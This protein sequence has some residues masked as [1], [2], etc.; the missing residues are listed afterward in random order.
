MSKSLFSPDFTHQNVLLLQGPVGPFFRRLSKDLMALGNRVFKINFNAGDALFYPSHAIHFKGENRDLLA[1]L[2]QFI[3]ANGIHC[4]AL[5]GDCRP[6]H[7]GVVDLAK[8]LGLTVYVF[9]EG[10]LRPDH[11]TIEQFGVNG[12]SSIPKN[13]D[14]YHDYAFESKKLSR[15]RVGS[16][17]WYAAAWAMLYYFAA[18]LGHLLFPKY[19]HHRPLRITEALY[20]LRGAWRKQMFKIRERGIEQR[21][22]HELSKQYFLAPLQVPTDAQIVHHSGF[23]STAEFI[24]DTVRS[25]ALHAPKSTYLVIKQHP[26][27]RGYSDYTQLIATCAHQHDCSERVL[28]IHDQNLPKLLNHALGVVT[29][30][31]TVG[32]SA[33]IHKTPTVTC[34]ESIY[35][36]PG[37]CYSGGL[38]QFWQAASGLSVD[39]DLLEKYLHY[40]EENCQVNGSFYR[41]IN[42]MPTHTGLAY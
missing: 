40:L 22:T 8:N 13:P 3:A 19:Q 29:I 36:I 32:L 18:N 31:S 10:Y 5:F 39:E 2:E 41:R 6:I 1:Y 17:F 30:N 14:F 12:N 7:A 33:I 23:E 24:S 34:G 21:L 38:D 11:I 25:F 15:I 26:F 37:L 20:W 35:D 28:Y 27:D 9:E 42:N 4:V 16:T